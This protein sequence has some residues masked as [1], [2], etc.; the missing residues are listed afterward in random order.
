MIKNKIL[1]SGILLILIVITFFQS[2]Y[3]YSQTEKEIEDN[4]RT[5]TY[6]RILARAQDDSVFIKVQDELN[7]DPKLESYILVV[8]ISDPFNQYV[9]IGDENSPD[10]SRFSWVQLSKQVQQELLNWTGTNKENLNKKKITYTSVFFDVFKKLKVKDAIA[11]PARERDILST[12][13]YINPYL[14]AFGGDP[15]GIPIKKSVGF[16]FQFGTPYSGP[17]ETDIVG[18]SFH[19]LGLT[20]GVTTRIKEFVLSTVGGGPVIAEPTQNLAN[21][22]NLFSPNIGMQFNYV[23]PFGNFFEIGYFTT[24]DSG[25][26]DPPV[27]VLNTVTKKP[28]PNNVI[29]GNYTNFEFRYPFRTFGSTR[30][31]LYFAQKY[32]EFHLGFI[33]R[34]MR[35]AGSQFD[36]RTDAT[37][38]SSKRNFQ[39]L[40][41]IMISNLGE[42]FALS[43]FALGPSF[44]FGTTYNNNFGALTILINMRLKIGDYFEER[45]GR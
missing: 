4:P 10:A 1:I 26:Y 22:N 40:M 43:S 17:M 9:I 36:F 5:W 2:T 27:T 32:S 30:S 39:L 16:S 13:A 15:L 24:I 3:I 8:N 34:E 37:F 31:K 12:T 41:E 29:H 33:G 6:F 45:A 7:I 35:L 18:T 23:L 20:V 21:Y 38:G 14:Q 25:E 42:G 44:R 28:M 19:I 11:P